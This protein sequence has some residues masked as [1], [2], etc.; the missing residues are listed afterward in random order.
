MTVG[1]DRLDVGLNVK[2]A[3]KGLCVPDFVRP[4]PNGQGWQ[5]TT[6]LTQMLTAYKVREFETSSVPQQGCREG[7]LKRGL[8]T[9]L[10]RSILRNGLATRV[11]RC[12]YTYESLILLANFRLGFRGW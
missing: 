11:Q 7:I 8:A 2:N 9:R 6:E 10:K 1:E 4:E 5:Y 3:P 12:G